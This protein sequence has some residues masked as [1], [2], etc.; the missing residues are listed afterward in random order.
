MMIFTRCS[1]YKIPVLPKPFGVEVMPWIPVL[2][3]T[4]K[5]KLN[6]HSLISW[7]GCVL[8]NKFEYI[9]KYYYTYLY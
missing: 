5:D 4:A 1:N 2:K 8:N 3:M 9:N 6:I 7:A